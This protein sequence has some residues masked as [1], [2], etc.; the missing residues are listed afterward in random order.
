MTSDS[1]SGIEVPEGITV[2]PDGALWFT[3]SGGDTIG[4]ITTSGTVTSYA[5]T[6]FFSSS[7]SITVGP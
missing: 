7:E 3:D 2:G 5:S 4:R 6:G 1:G